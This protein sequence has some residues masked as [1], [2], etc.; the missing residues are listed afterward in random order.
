MHPNGPAR[1]FSWPSKEVI[2]LVPLS[3]ILH[4]IEAPQPTTTRCRQYKLLDSDLKIIS[5]EFA[6]NV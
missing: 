5:C 3:H 2:C 4:K 1:S 6:K